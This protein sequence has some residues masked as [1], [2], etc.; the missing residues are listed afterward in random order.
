MATTSGRS[1][2]SCSTVNAALLN[3]DTPQQLWRHCRQTAPQRIGSSR[4]HPPTPAPPTVPPA[5]P[6]TPPSPLFFH[7]MLMTKGHR[8]P[9]FILPELL[10]VIS[11]YLFSL[12]KKKKTTFMKS[13]KR[14]N[15]ERTST[16]KQ[17]GQPP[18]PHQRQ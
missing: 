16:F 5:L 6:E 1:K 10:V 15:P 13:S 4:A 11:Y 17:Q 8:T 12:K 2:A 9:V 3:V 14:T 7:Y 18:H